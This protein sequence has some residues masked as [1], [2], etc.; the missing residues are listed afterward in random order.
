MFEE[1]HYTATWTIKDADKFKALANECTAAVEANEPG[2]KYYHWFFSPD[3]ATAYL[4]ERHSS[5]ESMVAHLEHIGP[6][7]GQLLEVSDLASLDAFGN[8]SEAAAAALAKLGSVA[9]AHFGG[10]ARS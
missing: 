7:L 4:L 2:M 9:N 1:I 8:A 3:G 5:S 10:F 6:L